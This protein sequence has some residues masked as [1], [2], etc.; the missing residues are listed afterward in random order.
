MLVSIGS[1]LYVFLRTPI[2]WP[3]Y[4]FLGSMI[5]FLVAWAASFAFASAAKEVGP[6]GQIGPIAEED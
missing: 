4:V 5:T 6:I 2:A 3:W 1:M